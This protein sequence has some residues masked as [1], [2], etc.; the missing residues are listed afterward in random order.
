MTTQS[1]AQAKPNESDQDAAIAAAEAAEAAIAALAE[2]YVV[3]VRDDLKTARDAFVKAG[4]TLPDNS[5]AIAEMFAVCHNIKGQGGS[6]GYQLMTNIGG[7]L[8]DFIRD[9]GSVSD[10]G[11]KVIE[12]HLAALEFVIDRQIK[13]DGGDAGQGLI[14]K[15]RGYVDAA[16]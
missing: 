4:E 12:A 7:S 2:N 16:G 1:S 3:W 14:Q 11:L 10:A 15:L 9:G 5:A 6:F 8:C 13:G